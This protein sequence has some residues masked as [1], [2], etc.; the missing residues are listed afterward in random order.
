VAL[1]TPAG[2]ADAPTAQQAAAAGLARLGPVEQRSIA[3][4][5]VGR[6]AAWWSPPRQAANNTLAYKAPPAVL[7]SDSPK[8]GSLQAYSNGQAAATK[9]GQPASGSSSPN[10]IPGRVS[11]DGVLG[12]LQFYCSLA[13]DAVMMRTAFSLSATTKRA[14]SA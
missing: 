8:T 13:A 7:M 2:Q 11:Q 10:I 1:I 5:P 14:N 12:R 3:S 6:L 4:R 9:A